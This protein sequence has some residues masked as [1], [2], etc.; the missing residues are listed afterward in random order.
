MKIS[1]NFMPAFYV[2]HAGL[3]YG[4]GY[5]RDPEYRGRVECG[6]SLFLYD[7]LGR[8][9]V[10]EARPRPT[11][12]ISIQPVDLVMG[13]QGAEWRM[14]LDATLESWGRPWKGL[15]IDEVQAIDARSASCHPLVDSI[16]VQYRTMEKL[17][18]ARA[19]IFGLKSGT[20]TIHTPYTTAHALCG[21]DFLGMLA[22]EPEAASVIME[23]VWQIYRAIFDRLIGVVGATIDRIQL[24]DCSASLLSEGLYRSAVLPVNL[25]AASGFARVG[26]HS[27]GPSTHLVGSFAALPRLDS[28]ELGPGTDLARSARLMPGAVLRPL[29]DP[30]VM[31]QG[32]RRDV[33]SL[34]RDIVDSAHGA[35]GVELCAWSFDRDTPLSN[36]EALYEAAQR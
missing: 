25:A 22:M 10:G 35:A 32:S 34:V 2:K 4:E 1:L 31:R 3:A 24:G 6:E 12:N 15:A 27:C 9:G 21:E 30:V 16:V 7:V 28:V 19:D 8:F 14:P 36:V 5:Y 13:T 33:G 20:M 29:V 11:G 26:Y 23:K 18:G 17:Y